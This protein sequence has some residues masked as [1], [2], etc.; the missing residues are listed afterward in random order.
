[1][2]SVFISY[3]RQDK[4]FADR[5][6]RLLEE[7]GHEIWMDKNRILGGAKYPDEIAAGIGAADVFMPL[8]S[9]KSIGSK[10]VAR[11]VFYAL[12]VG[13][14][15]VPVIMDFAKIPGGLKL[16][17]SD[18]NY[19]DFTGKLSD[20]DPWQYLEQSLAS[21]GSANGAYDKAVQKKT[22]YSALHN[23]L[24]SK[25]KRPVP[26]WAATGAVILAIAAVYAYHLSLQNLASPDSIFFPGIAAEVNQALKLSYTS[27]LGNTAVRAAAAV[28]VSRNSP[29]KAIWAP[30][31]NGQEL[32]SD[33]RYIIAFRPIQECHIYVFQIDSTGKLDWL[34]P[35]NPLGSH[36]SGRNPV[37]AD[38]WTKIPAADKAFLLDESLGVEHLFIV[39]TRRSW[40]ELEEALS[41]AIQANPQGK[42]VLAHLN[43]RPRGVAGTE[44]VV[45]GPVLPDLVVDNNKNLQV[46]KSIQGVLVV[47]FWF[48]HIKR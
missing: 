10:W 40:P 21:I 8:I 29:S 9:K 15:I 20:Y 2:A 35:E 24:Q 47:E 25:A 45:M 44:S 48:E 13:K 11:E 23:F 7:R 34:F 26:L 41:R 31:S 17:L 4:E 32:S 33:D 1:M 28:L 36:S 16:A 3:S 27:P 38:A 30:L 37:P 5:V 39:A 6:V 19:V 43:I 42:P 46:L 18:I 14:I 22:A 12:D